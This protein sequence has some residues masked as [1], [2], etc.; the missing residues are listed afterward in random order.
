MPYL[1]LRRHPRH[2]RHPRESGDPESKGN[3][4]LLCLCTGFANEWHA[5]CWGHE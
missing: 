3:N 2:P 4:E 5:L 1:S